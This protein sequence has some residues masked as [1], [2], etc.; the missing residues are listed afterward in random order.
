MEKYI[1]I[2]SSRDIWWD[3]MVEVEEERI[4]K[5]VF[6]LGYDDWIDKIT[7]RFPNC[8]TLEFHEQYW[9]GQYN[10]NS[11]ELLVNFTHS[12]RYNKVKDLCFKMMD[13]VDRVGLLRMVERE[14]LFHKWCTYATSIIEEV[15]PDFILLSESPH[16]YL[17][18]LFYELCEFKGIDSY[19]FGVITAI[20]PIMYLRRGISGEKIKVLEKKYSKKLDIRLIDEAK[21]FLNSKVQNSNDGNLIEKQIIGDQ[22]QL[23]LLMISPGY[24]FKRFMVEFCKKIIDVIS[25]G[26]A[27]GRIINKLPR[28]RLWLDKVLFSRAGLSLNAVHSI[29]ERMFKELERYPLQKSDNNLHKK[30]VYFPLHYEPERTSCPDG[31]EYGDQFNVVAILRA[32]LPEDIH[33]YLKE[34]PSQTYRARIG[35]LGRST[36]LYSA[37][38]SM[39]GVTVLHHSISSENMLKKSEFCVTLTGTTAIEAALSGKKALIFGKPWYLGCPN[40]YEYSIDLDIHTLLNRDLFH[41]SNVKEWIINFIKQYG[42]PGIQNPSGQKHFP[43]FS[44]SIEFKKAELNSMIDVVKFVRRE[45]TYG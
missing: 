25:F 44:N 35:Y 36:F 12:A 20:S 6:Y 13:R 19:S 10:I 41:S 1:Y 29:E 9:P 21:K 40:T 45:R 24:K 34:H 32:L 14:A 42:F 5:P 4:A 18:Y 28:Q 26:H 7:D 39:K 11:N 38:N 16:S 27:N 17:Q 22:K 33:I 15:K 37:I 3:L 23:H 2:S 8:K 30:F 43:E 31:G